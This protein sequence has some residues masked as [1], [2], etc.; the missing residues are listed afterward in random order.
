MG[1]KY[2]KS[3]NLGGGFRVNL[4]KSGVGYSWGT[5]GYRV[6]KKAG[7]V[8]KTYSITGTGLSW[9][10]EGGNKKQNAGVKTGN[11]QQPITAELENLVY[12][13]SGADVKNLV[14][15]NSQEFIDAIKQYSGIRKALIW[16]SVITL[17]LTLG[18]PFFIFFFIVAVA[19][20]IYL[21]VAKKIN[22][23]YEFDEYGTRR[24]QMMGQA[25]GKLINNKGLWQ[26]DTIQMNTS[27]K[28]N[29][30]AAQTVGKKPV[31][32]EKKKPYFLKTDATCYHIK[33]LRDDVYILP[34][35]IIVKGKKGWG[36]VEYSEMHIDVGNVIFI[37]NTAPPKDAEIMGYTWHYVN[38]NG[39]PD[40]RYSNNRQLPRCKYGT[41]EFKSK[42]GLD[43]IL[44]IS[45]VKNAQQFSS[46]VRTMIDEASEAR[47]IAEQE[48]TLI[49]EQM[50]NLE[51]PTDEVQKTALYKK[52]T[53]VT[54]DMK[55]IVNASEAKNVDEFILPDANAEER[56]L[57]ESFW[58]S[59]S[60]N[61][62]P[63]NCRCIRLED[64]SIAVEYKG[65]TIGSI[66]F[67]NGSSC[68]TYPM[69]NSGKSKQVE[70]T[71]E[72]LC[73]KVSNWLRYIMN[74]LYIGL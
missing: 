61:N 8:R 11:Y 54:Q 2:R 52:N 40:K 55:E 46:I 51:K 56:L 13:A 73:S 7:G 58:T 14:T 74:Y 3:I 70:G 6:T 34:D 31:K 69:G 15:D 5:K 28:T 72:E 21:S 30:G 20:L 25:M 71:S 43:V 44:Y 27:T 16:T 39:S 4:S 24:L 35:R 33:L 67:R 47:K 57:L 41:I 32:F 45:N 38:K 36:V 9:V 49:P 63:T 17:L 65:M 26:V 66:N 19:G 68:L 53:P 29:A 12:Q 42:T 50:V 23:E 64:G 1:L 10:D 22:V 37:E 59:L 60:E 48:K 62:L 18:T